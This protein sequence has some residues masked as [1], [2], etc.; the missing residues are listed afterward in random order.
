MENIN[1]I[2]INEYIKDELLDM[3]TYLKNHTEDYYG[4]DSLDWVDGLSEFD[5][6]K[7]YAQLIHIKTRLHEVM[8]WY[9]PILKLGN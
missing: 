1:N 5:G 4:N 9:T 7:L 2:K 3:K 8:K 6:K